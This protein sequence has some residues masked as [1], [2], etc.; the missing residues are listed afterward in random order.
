MFVAQ[1]GKDSSPDIQESVHNNI[2]DEYQR[3]I[4]QSL[5]TSFGLDFLITDQHGG[6]VDTIHSVR[7]IGKDPQMVY[8]NPKNAKAYEER[9]AYNYGE[10]HSDK[11]FTTIKHEAREY[12]QETGKNIRDEYT[13]KEIGFYGGTPAISPERKA[14]LDHIIETKSIH[15]D[16]GRVLSELRGIDLANA[17]ENLAFTN[18]S[19]NASMGA[20]AKTVNER[21]KKEY[22]CDAPMEM[23]D[24]K[25]YVVAHPELDEVTK[26]NLLRSYARSRKGYDDKIS[27]AYYT[28]PHFFRD[29]ATQ[30]S[31]MGVKMGLRQALGLVFS[32]IWFSVREVL[33]SPDESRDNIFQRIGQGIALGLERAKK[34]Y[35]EIWKRFIEGSA[36]GI[37][38]S[39][40]TTICNIFFTTAKRIV[41]IIRQS[42][43]SL[44][45]AINVLLFN[46]DDLLFGERIRAGA[47]ILATGA[48]IVV[49]YLVS[50]FVQKT[51]VGCLPAGI[52]QI[53]VTFC[54]AFISGIMSCSL[55]Y[56]LDHNS[57]INRIVA[58]LNKIPTIES[59]IHYYRQQ[60]AL[61][62]EYAAKLM[63]I[64]VISLHREMN[65][66]RIASQKL[67]LV[68]NDAELTTCLYEIYSDIGLDLPW[69]GGVPFSEFIKDQKSRLVFE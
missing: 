69:K 64:D 56:L 36:S 21:Y 6:D 39:I 53:V 42:W 63:D 48:S 50:D 17:R 60:S 23:V 16:R 68:S 24:T 7:E 45:E 1:I 27:K 44:I 18:K 37:L 62:V 19:L 8:K 51:P 10:Y 61:L 40:T 33:L 31:R 14:E 11:R 12:W 52:G 13:G 20:W 65:L 49:G 35:S 57:G 38:S 55:L 41:R 34:R 67:T 9:G 5:I 26:E 15:E 43:A 32:E 25:A 28:S 4:V 2:F 29:A 47:K 59:I 58:A 3:V 54:G 46:P 22:G 66:Y 30:A